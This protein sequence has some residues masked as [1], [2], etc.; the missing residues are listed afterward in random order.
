MEDRQELDR[1]CRLIW[2]QEGPAKVRVKETVHADFA[3]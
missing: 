3:R 1:L 2:E